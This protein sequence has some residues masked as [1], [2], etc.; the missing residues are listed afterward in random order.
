MKTLSAVIAAVLLSG[1]T[2]AT[3]MKPQKINSVYQ[4]KS[5]TGRMP[6]YPY[7][8][9]KDQI[10]GYVDIKMTYNEY[11]QLIDSDITESHPAGYFEKSALRYATDLEIDRVYRIPEI[12]ESV[13]QRLIFTIKDGKSSVEIKDICSDYMLIARGGKCD[14]VNVGDS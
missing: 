14:P 8:A 9:F 13:K 3:T 2:M 1:C 5:F 10:E 12:G 4:W 7:Q 11:G 6:I